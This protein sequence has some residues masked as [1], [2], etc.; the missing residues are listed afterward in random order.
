MITQIERAAGFRRDDTAAERLAKFE[1][2][3]DPSIGDEAIALVAGLAPEVSVSATGTTA[4][5][6]G[7]SAACAVIL[8]TLAACLGPARRT[9]RIQPIE[10]LKST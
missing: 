5:L 6:I 8:L 9:L 10:T 1:G 4:A 2:V 3:V 7:V